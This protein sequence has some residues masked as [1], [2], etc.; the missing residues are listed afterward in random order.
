MIEKE[1]EKTFEYVNPSGTT[2]SP[3]K[4]NLAEVISKKQ[5]SATK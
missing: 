5:P 3:A 1:H 2:Y 4:N